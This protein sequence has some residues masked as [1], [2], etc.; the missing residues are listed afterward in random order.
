[1]NLKPAFTYREGADRK[2]FVDGLRELA[3]FLVQ[4]P[5]VPVPYYPTM[6]L[7]VVADSD[8]TRRA[9]VAKIA[10]LLKV[11]MREDEGAI[12]AVRSFGPVEF[13]CWASTIAG[14][15]EWKARRSYDTS[16]QP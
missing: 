1:M 3:N 4:T 5:S 12:R 8:E 6:L 10:R 7:N 9:G 16:V 15:Q 13:Q 11:D 2:A 14:D